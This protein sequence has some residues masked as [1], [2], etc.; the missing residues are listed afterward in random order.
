VF[1]PETARRN[2]TVVII[3][4]ATGVAR[5]FYRAYAGFLAERGFVVVTYDYRGVGESRPERLQGFDGLLRDWGALDLAGVISWCK[6]LAPDRLLIVAHSVGGQIL[7]LAPNLS[8]VDAI[9]GIAAQEGFWGNWPFPRK[10]FIWTM[11]QIVM[12]LSI[13]LCGFLPAK[14]LGLGDDLPSGIGREW[15]R[16]AGN[17]S[18]LERLEGAAYDHY[19]GPMKL[20]GFDD[21]IL[22]P[23]KA[24]DRLQ[25]YFGGASI[26]RRQ[27]NPAD[28]GVNAIGHFG[29]FREKC[30][31][32]WNET[33]DWLSAAP[34]ARGAVR[35]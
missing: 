16:I 27:I 34:Y 11:S 3:N 2:G 9:L 12:P 31:P 35:A 29:F 33:A 6:E 13:R 5:G 4:S 10:L 24:V 14:R 15:V 23:R 19:F 8:G 32:L 26:E 30:R 18:Y 17:E 1:Q 22:A 21:D 20:Y 25:T 28:V 7:G